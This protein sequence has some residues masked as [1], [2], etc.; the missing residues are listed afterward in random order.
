[1]TNR[2]Q[3]TAVATATLAAAMVL[4]FLL[5]MSY[6]PVT[7]SPGGMAVAQQGYEPPPPTPTPVVTV[8]VPEASVTPVPPP[9]GGTSRI[10]QPG[11]PATVTAPAGDVVIQVPALATARTAQLEYKPVPVTAA[12]P[13][14]PGTRTLKTF[15]LNL[16]DD[17]GQPLT[18]VA[19]ITPVVVRVKYTSADLALVSGDFTRLR[20][21][22]YRPATKA[23][24][25]LP[26]AVD[27]ARQELVASVT[28]LTLFGVRAE[29]PPVQI[30]PTPTPT[31]VPP[32]VGDYAPG[33][34]VL[35]GVAGAGALLM[36]VGGLAVAWARR[37]A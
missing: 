37:R 33:P 24:I 23:W 21:M 7:A 20:V 28:H 15:E 29:R 27:F 32:R 30:T 13:A 10:I 36:A 11:Q 17:K 9:P 34:G 26:T 12:P 4:F 5:F 3:W 31:I 1:M 35:A 16:Y 8:I 14:D 2:R 18:D 22:V 6:G 25:P 19:L